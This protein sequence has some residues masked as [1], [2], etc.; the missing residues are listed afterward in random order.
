MDDLLPLDVNQRRELIRIL[1]DFIVEK[2]GLKPSAYQKLSVA[3]AS[4]II[5]PRLKF[6]NS[7][8]DGTV[9]ITQN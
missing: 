1:V 9:R 6:K 2:F 5:F 4:V 7:L 3:K 8:T